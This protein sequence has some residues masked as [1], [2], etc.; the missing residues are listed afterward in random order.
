MMQRNTRKKG[1]NYLRV[2]P[3]IDEIL[4]HFHLTEERLR[5]RKAWEIWELSHSI[6]MNV[7]ENSIYQN[8]YH[9]ALLISVETEFI[10]WTKI[11]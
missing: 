1:G 11:M 6:K 8:S 10:C 7:E 4:D 2:C 5:C 9:E 3:V